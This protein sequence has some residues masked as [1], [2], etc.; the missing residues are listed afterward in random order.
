MSCLIEGDELCAE[1]IGLEYPTA[2]DLHLYFYA[3]RDVASWAIANGF[4]WYR[5]S[6]LNYDPK[7]HLKHLLDPLD[8]YVRH[9][10]NIINP[11]L[12]RLLPCSNPRATTRP[13]RSSP[14]TG[15]SMN[16]LSQNPLGP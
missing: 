3:F 8:L 12:R 6:A 11:I 5:S 15:T 14:T 4:K 9:T 13:S 7:F 10:S 2:L 16:D 1:Y